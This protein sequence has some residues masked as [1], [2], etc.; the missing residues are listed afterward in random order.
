MQHFSMVLRLDQQVKTR[1]SE[2]SN[3]IDIQ[4]ARSWSAGVSVAARRLDIAIFPR[5]TLGDEQ[6]THVSSLE[7]TTSSLCHE[8]RTVIRTDVLRSTTHRKQ[9]LQNTDGIPAHRYLTY[10]V[11]TFSSTRPLHYLLMTSLTV[12]TSLGEEGFRCSSGVRP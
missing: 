8:L 1:W 6:C 5:A 3:A 2:I 12:S 4:G 7:P 11:D 10:V 9:V